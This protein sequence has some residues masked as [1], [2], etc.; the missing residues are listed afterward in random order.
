MKVE[1]KAEYAL[2]EAACKD[3]TGKTMIEWFAALKQQPELAGKRRETINWLYEAMNKNVWWPTTIWVEQ[4]RRDGVVMKDGKPDGYNI[5]VTKSVGRP[6]AEVFR[7]FT[8]GSV[9]KWL[10]DGA[11]ADKENNISDNN[12]NAAKMIRLRDNKDLR[13]EWTTG[14]GTDVTLLE[15]LFAEKAGKTG[16]TLNHSRILTREEADGLRAAWS[17]SLDNLKKMLEA[18]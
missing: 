18:N 11:K 10:E 5:C 3:A 1:L 16:I 17:R 12:K 9:A 15:V 13:Y 6:I 14:G 8:D 7:S 2:T 4:Q